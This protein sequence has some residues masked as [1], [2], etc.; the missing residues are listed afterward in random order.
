MDVFTRSSELELTDA[1]TVEGRIVPYDVESTVLD[2]HPDTGEV[3][4]FREV[5]RPGVFTAMIQGLTARGWTAAIS[6]NLDH[7]GDL[8]HTIGYASVIEE[9]DGG[10][11]GTFR[12]HDD[13][14]LA[15]VKSMLRSSHRGMSVGF[16]NQKHRTVDGLVERVRAHID[17]VAATPTPAYAGAMVMT[18]RADMSDLEVPTPH[19]DELRQYLESLRPVQ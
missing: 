9:R 1:G 19:V 7:N 6:L 17:H 5:F 10:A 14:T 2:V 12:L 3:T 8:G 16:R 15:K 13:P 18:V 4:R 11:W